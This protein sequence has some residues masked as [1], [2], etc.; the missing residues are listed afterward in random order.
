MNF[1]KLAIAVALLL[2]LTSNYASS[3][4]LAT[5]AKITNAAYLQSKLGSPSRG[6][7]RTL[8]IDTS[9]DAAY[10]AF[11]PGNARTKVQDTDMVRSIFIALCYVYRPDPCVGADP[12]V[13]VV[14]AD[15]DGVWRIESM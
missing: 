12:C 13:G 2:S 3:Y 7:E 1:C 8:G 15:G 4:E 11:S 10:R 9:T 5:H 6:L 14:L